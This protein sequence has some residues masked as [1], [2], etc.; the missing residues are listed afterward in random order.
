MFD[1]YRKIKIPRKPS[2]IDQHHSPGSYKI[3]ASGHCT[4][5]GAPEIICKLDDGVDQDGK[6]RNTVS[7]ANDEDYDKFLN[8]NLVFHEF[9]HCKTFDQIYDVMKGITEKIVDFLSNQS[10]L[11]QSQ[12]IPHTDVMKNKLLMEQIIQSSDDDLMT[13]FLAEMVATSKALQNK[14]IF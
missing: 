14:G 13:Y 4:T 10:Y 6:L 5:C 8:G 3:D 1:K 11:T 12:H 7:H 9:I 2:C